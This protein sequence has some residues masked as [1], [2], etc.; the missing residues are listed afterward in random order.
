MEDIIKKQIQDSISTKQEVLAKLVPDIEKTASTIITALKNGNKVLVCG[1]GGSA[2]DSQHL[3]G[4]LIVRFEAER[5]SLPAIA[6]T[7]DTSVLTAIG[8]DYGFDDIF[9][10][11]VDGLGVK[12]DVLIAISTSGNSQNILRA[13]E[14][15]KS[16]GMEVIGLT[17]R[18]GGK[19]KSLPIQNIIIPSP[20]TARIQ[21]CHILIIH[22]WCKLIDIAFA[23]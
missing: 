9:S 2:A 4:E 10:R 12:G 17:G 20:T 22:T 8:N 11:Q 7:T 5:K 21:E 14:A 18:D 19:M 1:N 16:K 6:L 15:A 23:R 3:A 13:I